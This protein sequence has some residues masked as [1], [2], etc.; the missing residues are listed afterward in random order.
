MPIEAAMSEVMQRFVAGLRRTQIA[1][2]VSFFPGLNL[3]V[4]EF[5]L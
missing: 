2:F 1:F 3:R 5:S 4:G